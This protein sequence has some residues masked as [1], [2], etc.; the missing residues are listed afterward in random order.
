MRAFVVAFLAI[1]CLSAAEV[2]AVTGR[3]W[4]GGLTE[5]RRTSPGKW[6]EF[7][8]NMP[9]HQFVEIAHT[10]D[11]VLLYDATRGYNV[12]LH[13]DKAVITKGTDAPITTAGHWL[14][15]GWKSADG[16]GHFTH[17]GGGKWQE[18]QN[19]APVFEF[20][21]NWRGLTEIQLFDMSRGITV[22][23]SADKFVAISGAETLVTVAGGW[24][25]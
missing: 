3:V 1:V 12:R 14:W 13:A 6:E 4:K 15:Q 5:Y 7:Q 25:D 21:E 18:Y 19:G 9:I 10:P 2:Q 8:N 22:K 11:S 16:K 24:S 17:L 23:L 20:R